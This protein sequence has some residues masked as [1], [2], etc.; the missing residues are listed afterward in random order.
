ME[1]DEKVI[2]TV[3]QYSDKMRIGSGLSRCSSVSGCAGAQLYQSEQ[4]GRS[5]SPFSGAVLTIRSTSPECWVWRTAKCPRTGRRSAF[6]V[7]DAI[8]GTLE[9][10]G[11]TMDDLVYVQILLDISH[12]GGFNGV[13]DVFCRFPAGPLSVPARCCS[14]PDLRFRRSR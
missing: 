7:L 9:E 1:I 5:G 4:S 2:K 8:K 13:S 12:Y 10:A 11:M 3:D 14:M 6:C